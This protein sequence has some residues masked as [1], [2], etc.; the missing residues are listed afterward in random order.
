MTF[1][2]GQDVQWSSSSNGSTK[3]KVGTVVAV[4]PPKTRPD[5]SGLMRKHGASSNY[6]YG[7]ERD[8]ESYVVLVS[9]GR[10]SKAKPVLYW[11]RA[12]ALR[13]ASA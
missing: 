2:C 11:P 3:R 5:I 8:H 4:V 9:G 7:M 12:A 10:T 1:N 13:K 6:G